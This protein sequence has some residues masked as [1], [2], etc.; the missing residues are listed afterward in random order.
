MRKKNID[1][2]VEGLPEAD[3]ILARQALKNPL[4]GVIQGASVKNL[5]Q[6][7]WRNR[8]Y[9]KE[10]RN[11]L[12]IISSL[13]LRTSLAA[14]RVLDGIN[15]SDIKKID[16]DAVEKIF[17]LGN[18]RSG[19]T[20]MHENMAHAVNNSLY[21]TSIDVTCP[22]SFVNSSKVMQSIAKIISPKERPL[23]K[24]PIDPE[25]SPQETQFAMM[26][27]LDFETSTEFFLFPDS[28]KEKQARLDMQ[29][30]S[31][32]EKVQYEDVYDFFLK[33]IIYK[34]RLDGRTNGDERMVIKNPSDTGNIPFLLES[35]PEAKFI[36]I[37]RNPYEV[38]RSLINATRS[39][40]MGLQ[41]QNKDFNELTEI[42]K[43]ASFEIYKILI[44]KYLADRELIPQGQLYEIKFEEFVVDRR[45]KTRKICEALDIKFD[46]ESE[47]YEGYLDSIRGYTKNKFSDM[48]MDLVKKINSELAFAFEAFDY[49]MITE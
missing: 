48:D 15:E 26:N 31:E 34:S 35:F 32:A 22:D 49:E 7:L 16:L 21:P 10:D 39:M 9:L 43:D 28:A 23:D 8:E 18:Y 13:L 30:Y 3:A 20:T 27:S 14:F 2:Y 24:M 4:T 36:N 5:I 25:K 33:K 1:K 12:R 47:D 37:V 40:M 46:L 11:T 44:K 29:N 42:A 17:V 6:I 41:L 38:I 45:N 19:T